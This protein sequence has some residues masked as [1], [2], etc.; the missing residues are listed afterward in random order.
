MRATQNYLGECTFNPFRPESNC[1]IPV[2]QTFGT[3][4]SRTATRSSSHC[5]QDAAWHL[6]QYHNLVWIGYSVTIDESGEPQIGAFDDI[7]DEALVDTAAG[8]KS[9]ISM[10]GMVCLHS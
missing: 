8:V 3:L 5:S 7:D 9:I 1:Y 6:K 4:F 2:L 10:I